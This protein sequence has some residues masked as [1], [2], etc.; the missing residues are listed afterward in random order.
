MA[1]PDI[2]WADRTSDTEDGGTEID[3]GPDEPVGTVENDGLLFFWGSDGNP[4]GVTMDGF[5]TEIALVDHT[6][7][8]GGV[9][10]GVRGAS[11]PDRVISWTSNED[12]SASIVRVVAGTFDAANM[13]DLLEEII[14]TGAV[15]PLDAG[16]MALDTAADREIVAFHIGDGTSFS[17]ITDSG[18]FT[19]PVA[20]NWTEQFDESFTSGGGR[21]AYGASSVPSTILDPA[22]RWTRADDEWITII[23]AVEPAGAAPDVFPPFPRR[24]HRRV[25]M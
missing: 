14:N 6:A 19:K 2:K 9:W 22:I 10:F 18:G 11:A 16:P 17:T 24:H 3:P 15:S 21:A 23:F 1:S 7:V 5:W 25:R 20:S 4:T 8:S 13:V 12:A